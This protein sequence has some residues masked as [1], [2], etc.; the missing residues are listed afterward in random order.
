MRLRLWR[1]ADRSTEAAKEHI[2]VAT[3]ETHAVMQQTTALVM[4][5]ACASWGCTQTLRSHLRPSKEMPNKET[6]Q[7]QLREMMIYFELNSFLLYIM[8]FQAVDL[9]LSPQQY[10]KLK[11]VVSLMIVDPQVEPMFGHLPDKYKGEMRGNLHKILE[12][13]DA[14]FV[15][16][17]AFDQALETL[18]LN[19]IKIAG[20]ESE[21][22]SSAEL[23]T[24][25]DLI[26]TGVVKALTD[27]NPGKFKE[28]IKTASAAIE[29]YERDGSSLPELLRQYQLEGNPSLPHVP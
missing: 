27:L 21:N 1:G 19:V 5:I 18:T 22:E 12:S 2:R 23:A 11:E 4:G 17:G 3:Q 24:V 26:K 29:I 6:W 20:Y 10:Q 8:G 14:R 13:A 9:N 28:L 25:R 16:A 7:P 15:Q